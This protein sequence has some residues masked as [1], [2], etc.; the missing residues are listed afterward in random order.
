MQ[1]K[2]K[3]WVSKVM[4][5]GVSQDRTSCASVEGKCML[6]TFCMV[7]MTVDFGLGQTWVRILPLTNVQ[8]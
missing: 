2:N 3:A 1:I 6:Y 4:L 8:C 5:V 7:V